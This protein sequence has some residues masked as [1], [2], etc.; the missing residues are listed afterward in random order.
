[1]L[2]VVFW[3]GWL[4]V[5]V[6]AMAYFAF[7]GTLEEAF[8]PTPQSKVADYVRAVARGDELAALAVWELPLEGTATNPLAV[9]AMSQRDQALAE[10]R[11]MV[12]RDLNAAGVTADFAIA[13][14][15]WWNGCCSPNVIEDPKSAGGARVTV[16]L[17]SADG[18]ERRY[19]FDVWHREGAY[20]GTFT[21]EPHHWALFDVYRQGEEPLY[22]RYE[23]G[24]Q[25]VVR[26]PERSPVP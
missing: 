25:G 18:G 5:A 17:R 12:T 16:I 4:V 11:V 21:G 10:R 26:L 20:Y 2:K 6:V 13:W 8:G 19:V 23:H 1:M 22:W 14:I 3:A 24:E 7:G 15:E 9:E